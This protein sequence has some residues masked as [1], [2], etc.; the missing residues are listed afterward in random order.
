MKNIA[1]F[2]ISLII[3]AA[4]YAQT[5]LP[6]HWNI[7]QFA[8]PTDP[9]TASSGWTT[10]RHLVEIQADGQLADITTDPSA[11]PSGFV[12][13]LDDGIIFRSDFVDALLAVNTDCT[14]LS[15][16]YERGGSDIVNVVL[17]LKAPST[18]ESSALANSTW[19]LIE[20][21]YPTTV[22][23]NGSQV[24]DSSSTP[25]LA[26][27]TLTFDANNG[28][29]I[30]LEDESITGT[31]VV[32]SQ[33]GEFIISVTVPGE[34]SFELNAYLNRTND[35]LAWV[36]AEEEDSAIFIGVRQ[37]PALDTQALRGTW[38][39]ATIT[40]PGE[41][42]FFTFNGIFDYE[43][44]LG[45]AYLMGDGTGYVAV[46]RSGPF[47]FSPTADSA[48]IQINSPDE[49]PQIIFINR[50]RS[51]GIL[52]ETSVFGENDLL[53]ISRRKPLPAIAQ[54]PGIE[55]ALNQ[56][57][58]GYDVSFD[59]ESSPDLEPANFSSVRSET[60]EVPAQG[61]KQFL[62]LLVNPPP[63]SQP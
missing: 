10:A 26:A 28:V 42:R 5:D 19:S 57:Q 48:G 50:S 51:F 4:A 37:E 43:Q 58:T 20:Y 32:G 13:L 62:R 54:I 33:P 11:Q 6:G 59:I 52:A 23:T 46:S 8:V 63:T 55:I 44:E 53:L 12:T 3:A 18:V 45:Q 47:T 36:L 9:P 56:A 14:V 31:Y 49:A 7:L 2:P 39:V 61:Q 1:V 41:S 25:D 35:V 27:G 38:D 40:V 24:V 15:G 30:N 22:Q 17:G 34:G 60:V 29:A 16:L 21:R